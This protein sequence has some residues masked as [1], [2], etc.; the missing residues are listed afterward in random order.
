[1]T[2]TGQFE[3]TG[4]MT[5]LHLSA[6]ALDAML[7]EWKTEGTA[8]QALADR[9]GLLI[10]DGRIPGGSRLPAERELSE[11]L[12]LSRSTIGAAY[13][14]LR[15]SGYLQSVRGSGSIAKNPAVDHAAPSENLGVINFTQAA[16][17]AIAGVD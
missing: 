17:P 15:A 8:Y 14:E 4:R 13:G 3:Y 2:S 6:R 7:G 12:A 16:L 5:P 11:R 1:M 9:I 10:A